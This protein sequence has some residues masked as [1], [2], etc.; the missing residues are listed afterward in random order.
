MTTTQTIKLNIIYN[1][2]ENQRNQMYTVKPPNTAG[3]GT[4]RKAVVQ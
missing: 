2:T 3:L 4:G 1:I